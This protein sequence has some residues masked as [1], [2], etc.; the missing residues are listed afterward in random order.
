MGYNGEA[1]LEVHN[2]EYGGVFP[3]WYDTATLGSSIVWDYTNSYD[4]G[5]NPAVALPTNSS[6]G[7]EV[8]N[9]NNGEGSLWYRIATVT[10]D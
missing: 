5:M 10:C 1:V 4:N 8:H 2:G 7:V 9:G 6:I 3:L